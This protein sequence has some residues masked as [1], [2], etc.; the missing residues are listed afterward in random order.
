[1]NEEKTIIK[2]IQFAY[3][4]SG[5]IV[6]FSDDIDLDSLEVCEYSDREGVVR[7]VPINSGFASNSNSNN[8]NEAYLSIAHR[9]L[10]LPFI[11][12]YV[13]DSKDNAHPIKFL[14]T[15][16][17]FFIK[18][19]RKVEGEKVMTNEMYISSAWKTNTNLY[20][21]IGNPLT[22]YNPPEEKMLYRIENL[23]V[24]PNMENPR[25]VQC[26]FNHEDQ[27]YKSVCLKEDAFDLEKGLLIC[28]AKYLDADKKYTSEGI[29][30]KAE[31][32]KWEK[33]YVKLIRG[34]IKDMNKK[35][36]EEELTKENARIEKER[37]ERKKQKNI[38]KKKARME[39]KRQEGIKATADAI[40][41]ANKIMNEKG[42]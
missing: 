1:M 40:I 11:T 12:G 14:M 25:V 38:A 32:L 34:A 24:F 20:N 31:Q 29:E 36:K 19:F 39:R 6:T 5:Q 41:L 15:T 10:T 26:S 16:K 13:C 22:I 4:E 21:N 9:Q 30:H 23:K 37:A 18:Y 7:R 8:V 33:K 2:I 35:L 28:M 3:A 17:K 42:E 27:L